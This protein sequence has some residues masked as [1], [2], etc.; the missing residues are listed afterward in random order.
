MKQLFSKG[1]LGLALAAVSVPAAAGETDCLASADPAFGALLVDD[2][3]A[4]EDIGEGPKSNFLAFTRAFEAC[5]KTHAVSEAD[6]A[7]F[8]EL[9][10]SHAF[11]GELR[12]RL[13]GL[14]ANVDL[15]DRTMAPLIPDASVSFEQMASGFPPEFEAEVERFVASGRANRKLAI[16]MVGAYLGA[17]HSITTAQMKWDAR[18]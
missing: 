3:L 11:R 8:R 1:L 9:N 14:G 16:R 5:V 15:I 2:F 6:T 7:L 4:A 17:Y 12:G 18:R 13:S 10:F